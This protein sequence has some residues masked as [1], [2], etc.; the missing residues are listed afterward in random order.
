MT[1]APR[2][3][4][5]PSD[6]GGVLRDLSSARTGYTAFAGGGQ[7]S[8]VPLTA[9]F[10]RVTVCA[11]AGD[12]VRLP[13]AV[14][15]ATCVVFNRGAASM[16]V[17]PMTGQSINALAANTALAV[18]AGASARFVCVATGIWDA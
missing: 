11:T 13:R 17:F 10:N 1:T 18:A 6:I 7:A 8:A 2:T 4:V 16:N 14:P 12:S 9:A 15:G 5:D 3:T